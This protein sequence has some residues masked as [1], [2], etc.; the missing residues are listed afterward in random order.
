[1][2]TEQRKTSQVCEW[3]KG[4]HDGRDIIDDDPRSCLHQ[5]QYMTQM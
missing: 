4:F 5:R 2:V 3:H 1:M